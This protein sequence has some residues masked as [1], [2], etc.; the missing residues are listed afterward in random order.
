M[1]GKILQFPKRDKYLKGSTK[2]TRTDGQVFDSI[3]LILEYAHECGNS[4]D[5]IVDSREL[6]EL[7]KSL[8]IFFGKMNNVD[9]K[10]LDWEKTLDIGNLYK[11]N[12]Y[13]ASLDKDED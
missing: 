9:P 13:L 6:G 10:H 12:G 2:F 11:D 1:T 8:H 5:P 4:L 7:I 3:E